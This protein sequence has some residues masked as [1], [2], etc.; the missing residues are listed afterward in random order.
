[1]ERGPVRILVIQ[2]ED[3][4]GPGLLGDRL[5]ACGAAVTLAAP[6]GV[7]AGAAAIPATPE[8]H[9]GVLVLGGSP[10]PTD[11]DRAPWLPRVRGLIAAALQSGTPLLGVCLGAQLLAYVAGGEVRPLD[12]GAE[13]GVHPLWPTEE[14]FSDP[15]L[16]GID[17]QS[18]AVQ[19]HELEIAELP[20]GAR[21]L[22]RGERCPQQAFR[23]GRTAWGLQFHLEADTGVV[24]EW[25]RTGA[26]DLDA[27]GI[28][29]A[30]LVAD[31]Q[32]AEPGLRALWEPVADCWLGVCIDARDRHDSA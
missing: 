15:L 22:C 1:M 6:P 31:V 13:I 21:L 17:G 30:D 4:A 27:A 2:H 8:G 12:G 19:W 23:I 7:V 16:G 25:A 11:D 32:A 24:R 3:D 14:A 29:A 28:A 5:R 18:Q 26:A 9:D 20:P 10:G